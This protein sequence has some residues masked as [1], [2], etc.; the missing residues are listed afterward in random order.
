MF[1]DRLYNYPHEIGCSK[2]YYR[3]RS[4]AD[5]MPKVVCLMLV[6]AMWYM[7]IDHLCFGISCQILKS[8]FFSGCSD[9]SNLASSWFCS[10]NQWFS[11]ASGQHQ[12]DASGIIMML[13][14][15]GWCCKNQLDAWESTWFF[16]RIM[17]PTHLR[18]HPRMTK[19]ADSK[20]K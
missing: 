10:K 13:P 11:T 7:Y 4:K 3:K 2:N 17:I 18:F 9:K 15:S 19:P 20:M 14:E 6:D 12:L 5:V 1:D 8:P 16:R